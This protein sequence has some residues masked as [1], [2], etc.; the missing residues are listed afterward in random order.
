ML[1]NLSVALLL[2][3]SPAP[4]AEPAPADAVQPPAAAQ[5]YKTKRVCRSVEVVGSSI[6]RTTC[7]TK[8]IAVEPANADREAEPASAPE[9]DA[10]SGE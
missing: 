2:G 6:P 9:S 3:A 7:T 10:P 1:A 8:R 5:Q 4:A